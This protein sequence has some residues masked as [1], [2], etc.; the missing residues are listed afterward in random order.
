MKEA[1]A[2]KD[3]EKVIIKT[4]DESSFNRMARGEILAID[5]ATTNRRQKRS[6][7]GDNIKVL[8]NKS[9]A[10]ITPRLFRHFAQAMVKVV[11]VGHIV[12]HSYQFIVYNLALFALIVATM[13]PE[14]MV[15]SFAV[16]MRLQ[17]F[18]R[19]AN[20]VSLVLFK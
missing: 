20:A 6:G 13:H 5:G 8:K 9:L 10:K 4:T 1:C 14:V 19:S 12:L 15:L 11:G 18:P 3:I 16:A 7:C 2:S 17:T